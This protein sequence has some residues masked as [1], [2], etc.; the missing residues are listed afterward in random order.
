MLRGSNGPLD[1]SSQTAASPA[2]SRIARLI[3]SEVVEV[4]T[5]QS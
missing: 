1:S 2:S 4:K 3:M 5:K